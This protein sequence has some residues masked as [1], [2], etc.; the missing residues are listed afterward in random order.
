MGPR[1][2]RL[3]VAISIVLVSISSISDF[4]AFSIPSREYFIEGKS[5]IGSVYIDGNR[6]LTEFINKTG[7]AGDGSESD[8]FFLSDWVFNAS[9]GSFCLSISST[10][11]HFIINNCNFTGTGSTYESTALVLDKV[12]NFTIQESSFIKNENGGAVIYSSS[13]S[14]VNSRFINNTIGL[15]TFNSDCLVE[16]CDFKENSRGVIS[17]GKV[18]VL[19]STFK[20][21]SRGIFIPS[22][23]ILICKD[24]IFISN[25]Y[26]IWT[27]FLGEITNNFFENNEKA[28]IW[29]DGYI[30]PNPCDISHNSFKNHPNS[31][32]VLNVYLY[33]AGYIYDG[34]MKVHNNTITNSKRGIFVS[35]DLNISNNLISGCTESSIEMVSGYIICRNNV[36]T[37]A[38]LKGNLDPY[39]NTHLDIDNSTLINGLP[40]LFLD[41]ESSMKVNSGYSQIFIRRCESIVITNQKMNTSPYSIMVYYSNNIVFENSTLKNMY[42]SN[43]ESSFLLDNNI[44]GQ[45]SG[46]DSEVTAR[47]NNFEN[48]PIDYFGSWEYSYDYEIDFNDNY[49]GKYYL[50]ENSTSDGTHW[51]RPYTIYHVTSDTKPRVFPF[52]YK[53]S[54]GP[55]FKEDMTPSSIMEHSNLTFAVKVVD[56][57][58]VRNVIVNYTLKGEIESCELERINEEVW[59]TNISLSDA[60]INIIYNFKAESVTGLT[61]KSERKSINILDRTSP[62]I[63]DQTLD[64]G[65]T[66]DP[67]LFVLDVTDNRNVEE[68]KVTYTFGNGVK[69]V[70][71]LKGGPLYKKE[72]NLPSDSV[73]PLH[74]S[75]IARDES[76]NI[77]TTKKRTLTIKDNDAPIIKFPSLLNTTTEVDTIFNAGQCY[78]NI[79]IVEYNWSFGEGFERYNLKGVR[80]SHIFSISGKYRARLTIEDEQGNFR[81]KEFQINVQKKNENPSAQMINIDIGPILD[82]ETGEPIEGASVIFYIDEGWV[83]NKTNVYGYVSFS[84]FKTEDDKE[85]TMKISKQGYRTLDHYNF[86]FR[87]GILK[88]AIP[89][90]ERIETESEEKNDPVEKPGDERTGEDDT[91][92]VEIQDSLDYLLI[93]LA[94]LAFTTISLIFIYLIY[95]RNSRL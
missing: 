52:G 94:V 34:V 82:N 53:G 8:P 33:G 14:V 50:N 70:I 56:F 39:S 84:I 57:H 26:G 85:I 25:K 37:G 32:M 54:R 63:L 31:S 72:I 4:P 24:C 1:S 45:I 3:L 49:Y 48:Y 41:H 36:I 22:D 7:S 40:V 30:D 79:G 42:I 83:I 19:N 23:N 62:K 16:K 68:V 17:K 11:F 74:Y 6:E 2:I 86:L 89:K 81:S 21:N 18:I 91:G 67:F 51:N 77:Q 95:R 9:G 10:D 35:G 87:E 78:D 59:E 61:S 90:M 28:G 44:S 43:T 65:T 66:G 12:E 88:L 58:F 93:L 71:D 69:K 92:E 27:Q 60:S 80:Q 64:S 73:E 15:N 46:I 29:I 55:I 47:R 20:N 5:I 75:I 13:G 38:G 76:G